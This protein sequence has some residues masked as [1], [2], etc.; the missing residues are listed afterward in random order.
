MKKCILWAVSILC[1]FIF[2]QV[3]LVK[4]SLVAYGYQNISQDPSGPNIQI[5]D[6]FY[7][8]T[9]K[10]HFGQRAWF[11]QFDSRKKAN[12]LYMPPGLRKL[13]SITLDQSSNL[14]FRSEAGSVI[15]SFYG[16]IKPGGI[17]GTFQVIQ[18]S[19]ENRG[20][21]NVFLQK[22]ELQRIGREMGAG[23]YGLYSNVEY[24]EDSGDLTGADLILIPNTDQLLGIFTDF[25]NEMTPYTIL[26]PKYSEGKLEFEIDRPNGKAHYSGPLSTKRV[27]LRRDD[28][29]ANP[30]ARSRA[31]TKQGAISTIFAE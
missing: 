21:V 4:L 18:D 17:E 10:D 22:I 13:I 28:S 19:Y 9:S 29:H 14:A 30:K 7:L 1:A 8:G 6:G 5:L 23:I 25:E 20:E 11:L 12:Y 3:A 26:N 2:Y 24:N 16:R 15:Y 27:I 31:L